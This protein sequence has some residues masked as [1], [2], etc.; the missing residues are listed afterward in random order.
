MGAVVNNDIPSTA[1][2]A[3]AGADKAQRE[4]N[5]LRHLVGWLQDRIGLLERAAGV[6][7]PP[8]PPLPS[9]RSYIEKQEARYR[10]SRPWRDR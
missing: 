5:D 4:I 3:Q 1:D 9:E 2:Y 7:S 8:R 6:V 10:I